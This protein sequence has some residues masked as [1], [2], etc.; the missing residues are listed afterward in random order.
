VVKPHPNFR[1]IATA[2]TIGKGDDT[3]MYTGTNVLN[4]AFLDRFG[5]VIQFDYPDASSEVK[6]VVAKTGLDP[7]TANK[8]REVA[9]LVRDG[10]SKEEAYCSFSTRRLLR[11]AEKIVALR[12][13]CRR[14]TS[15]CARRRSRSSTS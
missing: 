8:L 7:A 15:T 3:G 10:V 12:G 6:I 2:N 5:T 4:E 11:W 9:K 1:V 14:R 13:G